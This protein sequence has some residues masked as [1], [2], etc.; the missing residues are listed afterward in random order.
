MDFNIS[1]H[2]SYGMLLPMSVRT[3]PGATAFTVMRCFASSRAR[4]RVIPVTPAFAAA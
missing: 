4:T 3:T 2:T 1:V